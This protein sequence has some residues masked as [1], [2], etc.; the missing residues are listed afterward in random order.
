M[1]TTMIITMIIVTGLLELVL[2]WIPWQMLLRRKLDRPVAYAMGV[3]AIAAPYSVMMVSV[4]LTGCMYAWLLWAHIAVAGISVFA[5][6]GVD[7]FLRLRL[8][9]EADH[10]DAARLREAANGSTNL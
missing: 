3:L 9:G 8:T 2:H 10:R 5:A 6:Y 4:K 7:L 1:E